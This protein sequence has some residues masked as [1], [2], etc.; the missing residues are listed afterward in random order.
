M[1]HLSPRETDPRVLFP[2]HPARLCPPGSVAPM[3]RVLVSMKPE[4]RFPMLVLNA[5]PCVDGR[6]GCDEVFVRVEVSR[7]DE[8]R[9]EDESW[10]DAVHLVVLDLQQRSVRTA[11]R[12]RD[13]ADAAWVA[14]H[15]ETM[16]TAEE[17]DWICSD[18]RR[19][20]VMWAVHR[21]AH[22]PRRLQARRARH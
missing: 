4:C 8:N 17:W 15:L 11:A 9:K 22:R 5:H 20:R 19:A 18:W 10:A 16:L 3:P 13:D 1:P 7:L 12:S 6:C 21:S 2:E 14:S